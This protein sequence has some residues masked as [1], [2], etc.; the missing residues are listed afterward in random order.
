M[1]ETYQK[2]LPG[3]VDSEKPGPDMGKETCLPFS[4]IPRPLLRQGQP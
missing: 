3:M 2:G 1:K 4:V